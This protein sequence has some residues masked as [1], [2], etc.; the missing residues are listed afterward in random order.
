[1]RDR[2]RERARGS[3]CLDAMR[4]SISF[5]CFLCVVGLPSQSWSWLKSG[6]TGSRLAATWQFSSAGREMEKVHREEDRTLVI[7]LPTLHQQY[8]M[9]VQGV[10]LVHLHSFRPVRR[11]NLWALAL[12]LAI[13]GDEPT[14]KKGFSNSAPRNSAQKVY[15]G[16]SGV[17][18]S[19]STI[20]A[21]AT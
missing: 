20:V 19:W 15:G 3:V 13:R 14:R 18:T 5:P 8:G 21:C 16:R 2:Q 11:R 9:A 12:A 7:L 1:M 17:P 10:L 6:S 4:M